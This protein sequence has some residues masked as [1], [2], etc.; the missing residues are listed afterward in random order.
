MTAA[1]ISATQ[2]NLSWDN[3]PGAESYYLIEQIGGSWQVI[4]ILGNTTTSWTVGGLSPGTSYSFDVGAYNGFGISWG[5]PQQVS[6]QQAAPPAPAFT[7]SGVSATQATLQWNS[8]PGAQGYDIVDEINGNWT[9]VG[10]LGNDSTSC[11]VTG[12]TSGLTYGF[13][14]G[15]YNASGLSWGNPQ[16]ATTQLPAPPAP[17]F[18]ASGISTTQI[19]LSWNSVP[20]AQGYYVVEQTSNGWTLL[21]TL[22]AGSTGCTVNGL[23]PGTSYTFDVG[24]YNS[25]GV[26]WGTA[27]SASTESNSVSVNHPAAD[28]GYA[29][30]SGTLF[31]PNGPSFLDVQQ[32][33]AGDCWL[34][35][36]LAE[37]AARDPQDIV[38]MFTDLGSAWENGAQVEL[39]RVRFFNASGA[40]S[41]VTVDTELPDGGYYY[42]H[43]ANGHLW[44]A[45]AEKAYA[46]ANGLGIVTTQYRGSDSYDALNGGMASWAL[47]A[48]TGR[49]AADYYFNASNI[50]S[51]WEAGALIVISTTNPS[52]SSIVG[53]H[54]YAVVAYN[55]SSNQPFEVYN[56]WGTNSSGWAL[57]LYNG[58]QVYGLFT[59][60]AQFL[61]DNY[62]VESFGSGAVPDAQQNIPG[63]GS[64]SL[65]SVGLKPVES[66]SPAAAKLKQLPVASAPAPPATLPG[67]PFLGRWIAFGKPAKASLGPA[68]TMAN[69]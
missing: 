51:A 66:T 40:A 41:Y 16:F 59:A 44:V 1:S 54:A 34:M 27:Q 65:Q 25:A 19:G 38:N 56:P 8:V 5:N 58:Q 35:A 7:V 11:T 10:T 49:P 42:D 20:G 52:S 13:D 33:G 69:A 55:P 36:S 50:A 46:Q 39:Y 61:A 32:G 12:L 3:V 48:I 2:V 21:G 60:N 31:G 9:V 47:S 62:A 67:A 18:T 29:P 45:L 6:T 68:F 15:A 28:A 64:H 63:T 14:V 17:A 23:S 22:G 37:V 30:V 43:P 24:A 53:D 57:G 26:G 4:D